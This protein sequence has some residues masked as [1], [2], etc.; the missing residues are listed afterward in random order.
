MYIYIYTHTRVIVDKMSFLQFNIHCYVDHCILY[1]EI[2]YI[3]V[4]QNFSS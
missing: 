4:I 3:Y 2:I 1:W